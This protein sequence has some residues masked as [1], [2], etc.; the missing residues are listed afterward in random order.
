MQRVERKRH[1]GNDIVVVDYRGRIPPNSDR[2]FAA[3]DP[4][5]VASQFNHVFICISVD[6][7]ATCE[8]GKTHYRVAIGLKGG[9]VPFTP[10]LPC[11]PV[12]E[13]SRFC[14]HAILG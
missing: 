7:D 9:T 5:C 13:V 8:T 4:A 11:S 1:L 3:F 2:E 14:T 10:Y 12:F 6:A